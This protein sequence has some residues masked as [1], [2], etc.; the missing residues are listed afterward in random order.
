MVLLMLAALVSGLKTFWCLWKKKTTGTSNFYT[1]AGT[2][3]GC[4]SAYFLL[5]SR[6]VAFLRLWNFSGALLNH[7]WDRFGLFFTLLMSQLGGVLS[8]SSITFVFLERAVAANILIRKSSSS[9]KRVFGVGIVG[10]T[11]LALLFYM[12]DKHG[13]NMVLGSLVI[14]VVTLIWTFLAQKLREVLVRFPEATRSEHTR[15][16]RRAHDVTNLLLYYARAVKFS[17]GLS[18][19][20]QVSFVIA[21]YYAFNLYSQSLVN[22][23]LLAAYYALFRMHVVC[24]GFINPETS[25]ARPLSRQL[26][27]VQRFQRRHLIQAAGNGD[28]L[29]TQGEGMLVHHVRE[30]RAQSGFWVAGRRWNMAQATVAPGGPSTD[31]NAVIGS[32]SLPPGQPKGPAKGSGL[33]TSAGGLEGPPLLQR[34]QMQRG[35]LGVSSWKKWFSSNDRSASSSGQIARLMSSSR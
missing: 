14:V 1:V 20:T 17:I 22:L 34:G 10:Y 28:R 26:G 15:W 19:L 25:A 5:L 18:F 32:P 9:L 35:R 12:M 31:A 29:T 13:E 33:S 11:V 16:G 2:A 6:L 8:I 3:F 23:L 4:Q 21:E 27:W 30:N 7:E 24:F